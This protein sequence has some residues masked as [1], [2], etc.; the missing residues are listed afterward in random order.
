MKNKNEN[1]SFFH[2]QKHPSSKEKDELDFINEKT[3][4]NRYNVMKILKL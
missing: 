1:T 2:V 3:K 4:N